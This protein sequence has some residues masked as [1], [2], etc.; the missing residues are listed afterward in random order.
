[1]VVEAILSHRSKNRVDEITIKLA[2]KDYGKL[3]VE[4]AERTLRFWQLHNKI[5]K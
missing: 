4:T 1:M 2:S 3:S 5:E